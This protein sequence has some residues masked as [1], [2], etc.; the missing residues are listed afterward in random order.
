M[1]FRLQEDVLLMAQEVA[2]GPLSSWQLFSGTRMEHW[3]RFGPG[4]HLRCC[5]RT[6]GAVGK[7]LEFS[8]KKSYVFIIEMRQEIEISLNNLFLCEVCTKFGCLFSF[9]HSK[10]NVR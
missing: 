4:L 10:Q 3:S 1:M 9:E 8:G 7:R 5:S 2:R 6:W